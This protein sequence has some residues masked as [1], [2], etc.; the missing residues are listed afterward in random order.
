[1]RTLTLGVLAALALCTLAFG[2][3]RAAAATAVHC[4][5]NASDHATLQAAINAGGTVTVY[6]T[7]LGTYSVSVSDVTI[8]AGAPGATINGGGSS[9]T[10]VLDVFRPFGASH[11]LTLEGMTITGG[12]DGGINV[13]CGLCG[14]GNTLN[15]SNSTVTGNSK[16]PG[17]TGGGISGVSYSVMNISGSTI[18]NNTGGLGGGIAVGDASSLDMSDSIVTSNNAYRG[19][20]V[21]EGSDAQ[22]TISDSQVTQNS[23]TGP[24]GGVLAIGG[25]P[26][27]ENTKVSWNRSAMFGGGIASECSDL[28]L[29][30]TTVD[31]NRAAT[32]GGGISN[33]TPSDNDGSCIGDG[34]VEL[35]Q[36]TISTNVAAR[37]GGGVANFGDCGTTS[38]AADGSAF[39]GNLAT[40]GRGGAIFNS[41]AGCG[42]SSALV[43]L[44]HTT[45]GRLPYTV[46]PDR[47]E[48]GA[49]IFNAP[50]NGSSEVDLEASTAVSGN[51]A[52][53]HGGGVFD[54]PGAVL[55]VTGGA[56]VT[57]NIPDNIVNGSTCP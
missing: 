40:S 56:A 49:G 46:N 57:Q 6:G 38:L 51:Q 34:T 16:D 14:Y 47:A 26:D 30:G 32:D 41:N 5:D 50:G 39:G 12:A 25:A 7:C 42:G 54:C 36:S 53:V 27:L 10:A 9:E 44:S 8:Q 19:G 43:T 11:T 52:S 23:S 20:G 13:G 3:G 48:Y 15:M 22:V 33:G 28:T 29:T 18:S 17:T 2:A 21:W 1:M 24:G 35:D 31:H 55:S 4:A 45:V 37:N